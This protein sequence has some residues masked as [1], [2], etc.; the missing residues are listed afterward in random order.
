MNEDEI[1]QIESLTS[2]VKRLFDEQLTPAEIIAYELDLSHS[3]KATVFMSQKDEL[4]AFVSGQARVTIGDVRKM[5]ARANLMPH[6]F[7]PPKGKP[8]YFKNLAS[9]YFKQVYPG[10]TPVS[11][12]DLIYYKTLISQNPSLVEIKNIRSGVIKS[13]DPNAKN[14]WRAYK[15]FNYN[16]V[17]IEL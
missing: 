5:L 17:K 8:D 14:N 2:N 16:K 9:E 15:K 3:T 7:L 12:Q 11:D 6:K 4:F 13:F 10:M 1:F